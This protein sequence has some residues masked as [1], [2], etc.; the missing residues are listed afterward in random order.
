M[1][2]RQEKRVD[3]PRPDVQETD[4]GAKFIKASTETKIEPT[5]DLTPE[6]DKEDEPAVVEA[7]VVKEKESKKKGGRPK[8]DRK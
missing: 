2:I 6:D 3:A 8:K 4:Y 1:G 5:V 7:P